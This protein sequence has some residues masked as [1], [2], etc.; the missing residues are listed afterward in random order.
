MNSCQG[1]VLKFNASVMILFDHIFRFDDSDV[2]VT[3][4]KNL[5]VNL[6]E[7]VENNCVNSCFNPECSTCLSCIDKTNLYHIRE[8]HREHLNQ[9]NYV[10]V[11]PK[12]VHFND[13]EL[14][15]SM[16]I[17][18]QISINWFKGKCKIDKNWC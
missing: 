14:F 6:K 5:A 10:R 9:G 8:A 7:C 4:E 18:N 15:N 12:K 17:N 13:K 2:A 16:T 1:R 3:N 11:F